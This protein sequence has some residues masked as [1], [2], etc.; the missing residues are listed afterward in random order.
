MSYYDKTLRDLQEQTVRKRKLEE[1]LK[2][3]YSRQEALSQHIYELEKSKIDEQTDVDRLEGRSLAS[4]FYHVVGK[5]DEKLTKERQ[6]AYAARVKYDTAVVELAALREDLARKEAEWERLKGCEQR[7]EQLMQEKKEAL[8][9]AGG[10]AAQK[11]LELEQRLCYL[12][13]QDQELQEAVTAGE[14]ALGTA[15]EILRELDSAEDW[16]V[17]DL[18]GGGVIADVVKYDHLDHA[19]AQVEQLQVQL[20]RFKTE[21]ADVNCS[22]DIKIQADGFLRF[23]DFFFDGLFVDWA[24]MDK[25]KQSKMEIE[26]TRQGILEVLSFLMKQKTDA[27]RLQLYEW[28]RQLVQ[29]TELQNPTK[30]Q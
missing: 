19:Q 7:Y 15:E 22:V 9:A 1:M 2:D 25:I 18:F 20:E 16:A 14:I 30:K 5:M 10:E 12:E 29:D 24:V 4:F 21:L 6:E 3:L 27:E 28:L 17:W 13:V 23:A 8:K 26:K 11:I